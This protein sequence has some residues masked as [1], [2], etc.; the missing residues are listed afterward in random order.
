MDDTRLAGLLL[1][2]CAESA[3]LDHTVDPPVWHDTHDWREGAQLFHGLVEALIRVSDG[4]GFVTY[5]D[6]YDA[7][8]STLDGSPGDCGNRS[9]WAAFCRLLG[10]E[11]RG[12]G[13]V[14]QL[15]V[16][17]FDA[18]YARYTLPMARNLAECMG[19]DPAS[20]PE[21]PFGD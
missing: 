13:P 19:I 4:R 2:R 10:I 1:T 3:D 5:D 8:A 14:P 12:T 15:T 18:Y 11:L 21:T 7:T 17:N 6:L 9:F 20:I 16:A